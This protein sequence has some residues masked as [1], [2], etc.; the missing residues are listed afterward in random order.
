MKVT[1]AVCYLEFFGSCEIVV[2]QHYS[3]FIT[4]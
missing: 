3:D 1:D 2:K 4:P